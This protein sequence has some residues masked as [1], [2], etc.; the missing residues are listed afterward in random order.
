MSGFAR[1]L[2]VALLA[3]G[4]LGFGAMG[5]CGGYFTLSLMTERNAASLLIISLPF[6]VGGFFMVWVCANKIRR[7]LGDPQQDE[8]AAP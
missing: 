2:L 6:L 1:G 4:V 5:L 7:L 8:K 3:V